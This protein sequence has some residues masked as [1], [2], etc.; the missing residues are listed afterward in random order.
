MH[1]V[2]FPRPLLIA[3][4]FPPVD[5]IC[6]MYE[7]VGMIDHSAKLPSLLSLPLA[8]SEARLSPTPLQESSG[9]LRHLPYPK[10]LFLFL[11]RLIL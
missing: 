1:T 6:G 7:E 5:T 3:S 9:E 10:L 4:A 8:G 11:P 2:S